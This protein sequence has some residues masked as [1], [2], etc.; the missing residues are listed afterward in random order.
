V[1]GSSSVDGRTVTHSAPVSLQVLPPETQ[2][3][4]GRIMTTDSIPQPIPGVSVALGSAF[5]VTD[6]AGNFVLLAPPSGR[7]M[8]FVDGRTASAPDAQFP[9]V[10]VQIDVASSGATRVPFTIYLPKLD[11]GNAIA[12]PLD[13]AGFTT[14]QVK[15]T[16]PR[17][18][19]LEI[20]VPTG[21]RIIG[22]DGNPVGQLVITP[23]PIDRSPMPFP[24]GVTFP[25][26]F[27]IN[28]GG[29]VPSQPL[30]ITF[31]NPQAAPPGTR[32]DLYYFD[33]AIGNWNIWGTGTASDDGRRI[34]SDPGFGLPRLA[35]AA[36]NRIARPAASPS[37]CPPA[38]SP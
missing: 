13:A 9:I 16:T 25:L 10:E 6:A 37:I 23:V 22:P 7:N 21:T 32:A 4:T 18:P 36:G 33:L 26:L 11:T 31:P 30:P 8:L 3:V 2:A 1:T 20:T 38:A 34:V 12:L 19:G 17:I 14:Q 28:P 27:A 29:A 5:V 35:S 24:A 15:A